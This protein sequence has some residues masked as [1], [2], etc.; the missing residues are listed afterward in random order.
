[1]HRN[2]AETD[3]NSDLEKVPCIHLT[4]RSVWVTGSSTGIGRAAALAFAENG[5]DVVVHTRQSVDK[6]NELV[7]EIRRIGRRA[8]LLKSS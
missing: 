7:G 8:L 6:G 4:S 1:M 5:A 3:I 2:Q